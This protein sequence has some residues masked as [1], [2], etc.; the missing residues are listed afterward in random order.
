MTEP[1]IPV[2]WIILYVAALLFPLVFVSVLL[3][4]WT[5]PNAHDDLGAHC[6]PP[7]TF[8]LADPTEGD[9]REHA[10]TTDDPDQPYEV[11]DD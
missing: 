6:D 10:Q 5:K 3:G 8:D 2:W 4:T 1:L 11:T 9:I 7:D